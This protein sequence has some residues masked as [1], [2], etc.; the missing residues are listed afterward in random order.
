[1][2]RLA[3]VFQGSSLRARAMRSSVLTVGGFG[4]S[5]I[6][7]LASNLILTRLLFPE[8]F[9]MMALVM[10]F[11]QGLYQFSDVG[12]GPAIMQSKRGDDPRFLN[13]AWT[14]QA[15]RGVLLWLAASVLAYPMALLYGEPQLMQLLPVAALTLVI[16]GF[17]PTRLMLANRHLQL[18]RVTAIDIVTQLSGILSA[19]V[20]AYLTQSVWALVFSSIISSLVQLALFWIYLEGH[21][22][23]FEWERPAAHEL[24]NFGKWI[25]LST[26]AGF[27]F[28]QSDKM[29]L[30]KYL[31]LD[32][33]GVYNIGFFLASF[34][35]LLGVSVT[36]KL[37]IPLYR[38]RPPRESAANFTALRKMRFVVSGGLLFGV[39]VLAFAGV[40]LVAFL[41]DPRYHSA[42]IIVTII[43]CMQVPHIIVLTY[44]QAALAAGDS[45]RF[46][47]LAA[48]RA[49]VMLAVMLIAL[50]TFGLIGA[51]F[52]IGIAM[53]LIYP[54]V[55][56]LARRMGAWDPVHDLV[57]ALLGSV[58][59]ALAI[60]MNWDSVVQ[61]AAMS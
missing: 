23:R 12:V 27:L 49:V 17:N 32:Q 8:A 35:L 18:G 2:S 50:E 55:I 53:V 30:G 10:V 46:F 16:Q 25:F 9:G 41:Y 42:G 38:E 34:P 44:D 5:Q 39:A 11:I 60:W 19:V 3:S 31:P 45:K 7:R 52:S 20:L 26:V 47:V 1:M 28:N 29:L 4:A 59:I 61:L 40:P 37:L 51:L 43:A 33:F 58:V 36:H 6:I 56:W 15:G 54:V 48:T 13:T 22:D 21:R 14:I 24:I 57:F